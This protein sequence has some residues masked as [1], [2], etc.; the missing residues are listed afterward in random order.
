MQSSH[1]QTTDLAA[2]SESS[3][4]VGSRGFTWLLSFFASTLGLHARTEDGV[5]ARYAGCGWN[6][7]TESQMIGDITGGHRPHI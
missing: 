3:S 6:D 2:C 4:V 5:G 1:A 7:T